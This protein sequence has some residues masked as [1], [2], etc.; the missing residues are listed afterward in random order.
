MTF[1]KLQAVKW[2]KKNINRIIAR[3]QKPSEVKFKK[4]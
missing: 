1:V 4:I 2:Y 3:L